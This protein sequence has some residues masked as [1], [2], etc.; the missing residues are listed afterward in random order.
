MATGAGFVVSLSQELQEAL[1]L[2]G[3]LGLQMPN[4]FQALEQSLHFLFVLAAE[5]GVTER[6]RRVLIK[7]LTLQIL[8]WLAGSGSGGQ[9]PPE[10]TIG[11][12][13]EKSF[14]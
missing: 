10:F 9:S 8:G 12:T 7:R 1:L 6:N 3:A 11:N 5:N 14:P 2:V 13:V 4:R